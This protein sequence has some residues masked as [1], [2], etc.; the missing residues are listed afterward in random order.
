MTSVPYQVSRF[1]PDT[2]QLDTFWLGALAFHSEN[3]FSFCG[4]SDHMQLPKSASPV[5]IPF[6]PAVAGRE[7]S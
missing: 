6:L 7:R 2:P 1:A 4:R 3:T 5:R